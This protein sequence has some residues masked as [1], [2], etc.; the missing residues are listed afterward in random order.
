[1]GFELALKKGRDTFYQLSYFVLAYL[2]WT[3]SLTWTHSPLLNK[4]IITWTNKHP[5]STSHKVKRS[6]YLLRSL[7]YSE[8]FWVIMSEKCQSQKRGT[9]FFGLRG[10]LLFWRVSSVKK[11]QMPSSGPP[12]EEWLVLL[13]RSKFASLLITT[14][15]FS[16][17]SVHLPAKKMIPPRKRSASAGSPHMKTQ[18]P[19]YK[20]RVTAPQWEGPDESRIQQHWHYIPHYTEKSPDLLCVCAWLLNIRL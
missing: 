8:F 20:T 18:F 16:R 12:T 5:V 10:H 7:V 9:A 13:S 14:R 3:F 15:W 4:M 19:Q 2:N 11:Q 6:K 1:M 17:G